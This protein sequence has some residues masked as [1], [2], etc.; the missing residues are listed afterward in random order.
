VLDWPAQL[1]RHQEAEGLR[2]KLFVSEFQ[3]LRLR[4]Q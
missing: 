2:R 1:V 3:L 4:S